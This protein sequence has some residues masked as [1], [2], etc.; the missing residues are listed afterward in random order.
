MKIMHEDFSYSCDVCEHK[1][2][3]KANLK[4]HTDAKHLGIK[5]ECDECEFKGSQPGTLKI[6]KKTKH[7]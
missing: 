3:T 5:Y 4:L 1:S 7:L 6:H 2:S